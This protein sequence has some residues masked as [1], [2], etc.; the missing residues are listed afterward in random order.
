MQKFAKLLQVMCTVRCRRGRL[1]AVQWRKCERVQVPRHRQ[2]NDVLRRTGPVPQA[3]RLPG[4]RQH[5]QRTGL[6]RGIP[7]ARTTPSRS[8]S[9]TP[10]HC[11]VLY[12]S[13]IATLSQVDRLLR[14][15]VACVMCLSIYLVDV[16]HKVTHNLQDSFSST[17][18]DL[19]IGL[20]GNL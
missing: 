14:A 18:V 10:F 4:T 5:H 17:T 9:C 20:T 2:I 8:V 13:T 7:P 16:V 1:G 3:R 19:N 11:I 12:S 6:H 15:E